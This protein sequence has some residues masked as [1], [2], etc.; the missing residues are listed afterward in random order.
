MTQALID[1][2]DWRAV[3]AAYRALRVLGPWIKSPGDDR[4]QRHY[5]GG[6]SHG[7]AVWVQTGGGGLYYYRTP[8]VNGS[9]QTPE[10]AMATCDMIMSAWI[11]DNEEVR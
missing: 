11:L 7:V 10:A 3:V 2:N 8:G 5:V 4:W 6:P 9:C 1:P